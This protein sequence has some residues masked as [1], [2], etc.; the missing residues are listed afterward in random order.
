M[1][2]I[3]TPSS[4][5]VTAITCLAIFTAAG[6]TS[7]KKEKADQMGTTPTIGFNLGAIMDCHKEQNQYPSQIT[8][9][10]EGTWV[11][12]SNTC[13]WT[14]DSTF[15]PDKHV[16]VTFTDAGV[17]KVFEDSKIESEGTWKLSQAGPDTWSI[18]TEKPSAYLNG[19]VYL[20]KNEVVFFS[21]YID[22]CDYYFVR[23]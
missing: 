15:T 16:V 12:T 6:F 20:C 11:W 18:I 4:I 2:K 21:S 13:Y 17:Y 1:S 7:C 8:A 10:L 5:A 14:G 23:R 3:H 22:G 19:Y 9:G